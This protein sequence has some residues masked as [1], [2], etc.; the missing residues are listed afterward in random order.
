MQSI[1]GNSAN[2]MF[3]NDTGNLATVKIQRLDNSTIVGQPLSHIE[4]TSR[5][6]PRS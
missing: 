6:T 1:R 3:L 5:S 2:G 4:T